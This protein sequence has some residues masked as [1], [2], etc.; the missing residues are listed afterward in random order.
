MTTEDRPTFLERR[1]A[2]AARGSSVRAEVLGG[3]ATFFTMAYVLFVNAD[4]LGAVADR[5]GIGSKLVPVPCDQP[6]RW[7]NLVPCDQPLR[8]ALS[9]R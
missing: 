5:E 8:W 2:I 9:S 7:A 6:L 3:V 1:F 4:V